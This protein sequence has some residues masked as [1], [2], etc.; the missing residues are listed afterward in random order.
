MPLPFLKP[1]AASGAI[2]TTKVRTP[3]APQDKPEGAEDNT[4][5]LAGAEDFLRAIQAD[6]K[7]AVA[8]AFKAMF[9]M[10][11][12]EPHDE[13]PHPETEESNE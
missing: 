1:K 8:E 5:M 12:L 6:D 2:L 10:C 7:K 9:E 3:D 13:T 11:E 4:G